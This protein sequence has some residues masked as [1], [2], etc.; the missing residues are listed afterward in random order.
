MAPERIEAGNGA[1]PDGLGE[2]IARHGLIARGGFVFEPG[3]ER[4]AGPSGG[5]AGSLALIGNAGGGMWRHFSAWLARQGDVPAEPL[6]CWSR[7]VIGAVA[8]QFGALAVFPSDEPYAPF[9]RW[10]M[11][12]EGLRASPLGM[13]IH[14]SY[15]LWHAYRGALLFDAPVGLEAAGQAIHPCDSCAEKP[16]LHACPVGAFSESN[17]DVAACR[18]HID[19]GAVPHC[20][21][22]GCRA[23]DACPVGR[24]WRYGAEQVHFHMRAFAGA[25]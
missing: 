9:Q 3:E 25:R 6:D 2:A 21:R 24:L 12:A 10:A 4:P 16:C 22:L 18:S 20:Q 19:S 8:R 17:Y 14:P 15:G 11:R 1:G 5:P 23:R 13:L 7:E